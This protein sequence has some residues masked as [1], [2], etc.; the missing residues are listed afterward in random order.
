MLVL[1]V[2]KEEPDDYLDHYK[3]DIVL[4]VNDEEVY[5]EKFDGYGA[6]TGKSIIEMLARCLKSL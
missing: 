4:Y 3:D 1:T 5:R 2:K 6:P